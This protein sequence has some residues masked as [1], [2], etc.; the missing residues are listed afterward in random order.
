MP[1]SIHE[2]K[3]I[4][5]QT[6]HKNIGDKEFVREHV[7]QWNIDI[8]N[9]VLYQLKQIQ[10]RNKDQQTKYVVTVLIGEKAKEMN[11]GLHAALSCLWDGTTDGCISVKWENKNVFSIVNVFGLLT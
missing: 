1:F 9:E 6:L 2:I 8:L 4:I 10:Y 3:T 5:T 7:R 11:V